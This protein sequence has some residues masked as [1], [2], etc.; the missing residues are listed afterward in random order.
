MRCVVFCC[1]TFVK[2]FYD[3]KS[4]VKLE[5]HSLYYILNTLPK[6]NLSN[7]MAKEMRIKS[8]ICS[9]YING[10]LKSSIIIMNNIIISH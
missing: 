7:R 1:F 6:I 9:I 10:K 5:E 3:Q 8:L 2:K 4:D